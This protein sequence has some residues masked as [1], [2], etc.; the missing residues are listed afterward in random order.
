MFL[1]RVPLFLVTLFLALVLDFIWVGMFAK[2]FYQQEI[3]FLLASSVYWPAALLFYIFYSIALIIFVLE[4][5]LRTRSVKRALVLGALF[6]FTAYM[7]Y[8]LT[9]LATT[10]DW[11]F[12]VTVVDIAWGTVMT[13]LV[14]ISAY[15]IGSKLLKV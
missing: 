3:G 8:D 2:E 13:A 15:L 1:R 10:R 4:P 14:S 12:A 7:T 5:A 9:S 6:G 11:S